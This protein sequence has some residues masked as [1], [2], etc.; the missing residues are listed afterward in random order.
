MSSAVSPSKPFI[1]KA[2]LHDCLVV[3][4]NMREEDVQEIWHSSRTQ[5]LD[6]LVRG[7]IDSTETYAIERNGAP[8]GIF[9]VVSF[10]GQGAGPWMLGT[11]DLS[12][13]RSL[14]RE[15]RERLDTWQSRYCYLTNAAWSKNTVHIEW[16]K[17]LGFHFE[18][19]DIRHD[20]ETFLYF[21][22]D[23]RDV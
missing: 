21:H 6:A 9:G 4:E 20:G 3:A 10:L 18:G 12:R 1:R 17:W 22:K 23:T 5:P 2:T 15:C 8:V 11:P 7:F 16:I 14:L 13:C 19:S